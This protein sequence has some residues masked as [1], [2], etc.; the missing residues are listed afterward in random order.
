MM[1]SYKRVQHAASTARN[2]KAAKWLANDWMARR[3][4]AQSGGGKAQEQ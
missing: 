4:A 2:Q 3:L 1:A